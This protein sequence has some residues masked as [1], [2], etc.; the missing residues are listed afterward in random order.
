MAI[1]AA[2]LS[3]RIMTG[4]I[5]PDRSM[6]PFKLVLQAQR[7]RQMRQ[8]RAER[9]G[10]DRIHAGEDPAEAVPNPAILL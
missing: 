2:T 5:L 6:A 8:S 3:D 4:R 10:L 9:Q 1:L 7:R